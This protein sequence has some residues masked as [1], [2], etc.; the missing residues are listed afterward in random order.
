[1]GT[2]LGRC[3]GKPSFSAFRGATE[4]LVKNVHPVVKIAEFDGDETGNLVGKIAEIKRQ[5]WAD[6]DDLSA[7]TPKRK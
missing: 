6:S 2:R 3:E 4:D 1:M 7:R 5:R